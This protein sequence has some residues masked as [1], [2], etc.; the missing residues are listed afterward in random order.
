MER[1]KKL[2]YF[3][4][5]LFPLGA[6]AHDI[7]VWKTG[8]HPFA[9]AALGW[10]TKT[11]IPEYHQMVVDIL[12][13]ELFNQILTPILELR[14][15]YAGIGVVVLYFVLNFAVKKIAER[16]QSAPKAKDTSFKYKRR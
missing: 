11:Y 2:I 6:L 16:T 3:F 7:Y 4:L 15:F 10:I 13:P 9:F 12:G 1:E 14:A 8:E 5:A